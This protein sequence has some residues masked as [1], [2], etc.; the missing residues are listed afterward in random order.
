MVLEKTQKLKHLIEFQSDVSRLELPER[1][2]FPFYYTPHPLAIQACEELQQYLEEQQEWEHN[3]G[4][5][6]GQKGLVIGKMFGVLVVKTPSGKLAY[7]AAFSGKLANSNE[8]D[9]FVPPVFDVLQEDGFYKQG[10]QRLNELTK[11]IESLDKES[12]VEELLVNLKELKK[13]QGIALKS[14]KEQAKLAKKERDKRRKEGEGGD[15]TS[16]EALEKSLVAESIHWSYGLKKLQLEWKE[17]IAHAT[18]AVAQA[19]ARLNTLKQQRKEKSARLQQEIFDHYYFLNQAKEKKSLT[20]IFDRERG[21]KPP[22]GSGECAA[23]KLLHYAFLNDLTPVVMAEFWWGASPLSEVRKHKQFYPACKSKC[24]PI[25][26]HM[27]SK[28]LMDP[29][30]FLENP[31]AGKEL[32]IIFEDEDLVVVNKPSEFLSVPGKSINDSVLSRLKEMYPDAT[33]PLLL[34]R[35]DMSTSG[36]LVAA[37]NEATHKYIQQQFIARKVKKKYVALLDGKLS[38][39]EG[40]INLPLRVDLDDRPRQL[41][42]YEYGKNAETIWKFV[43]ENEGKTKVHFFPVTGR[44]HQLRVH[45]SHPLGLN[46]PIVGDDLYGKKSSRLHLHA[47]YISFIHP[48]TR[49]VVSFAKKESF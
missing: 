12:G 10:E 24:E 9:V 30:P 38:Q 26:G 29:N 45:A 6:E 5:K 7:L 27:L 11:E 1:F 34:H 44:T 16:R 22:A 47:A 40:R 8:F 33:G 28:T 19:E 49:R 25:L 48:R 20:T 18:E 21:I 14:Y 17:K 2:T 13:E 3:F 32:E 31:A 37:K 15:E 41:V 46:C 39:K 42:C 35:L 4:L 23:P 36:I 43:E